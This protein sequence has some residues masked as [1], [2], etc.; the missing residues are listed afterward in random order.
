MITKPGAKIRVFMGRAPSGQTDG[1]VH[2][3]PTT[4][5]H[6]ARESLA[7]HNNDVFFALVDTGADYIGIDKSV[8]EMLAL[9][10]AGNG[11]G[12]G[13]FGM[14][15]GLQYVH[16]SLIFPGAGI[17]FEVPQAAVIDFRA[18]GQTFDVLLGRCFLRH[19]RLTV[20]GPNSN[21]DLE[22]T[23]IPPSTG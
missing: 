12:R 11:I 10:T 14:Q 22:W 16:I 2:S 5:V 15:A 1:F 17:H 3:P 20:D 13:A 19:C 21:Y 4:T 18:Q 6:I 9:R 8:V 7:Q 23:G